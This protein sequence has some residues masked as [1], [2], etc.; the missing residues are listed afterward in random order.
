MLGIARLSL[1]SWRTGWFS[2][3]EGDFRVRTRM[4][5][6]LA[7]GAKYCLV[8]RDPAVP[9]VICYPAWGMGF[10]VNRP[11]FSCATVVLCGCVWAAGPIAARAQ[12]SAAPVKP[13]AAS[14][15][16]ESA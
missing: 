10:S 14:P 1:E 6:G 16:P 5:D 7:Q 9:P 4:P 13:P 8:G 3:R 15:S 12:E 11:Y 2:E